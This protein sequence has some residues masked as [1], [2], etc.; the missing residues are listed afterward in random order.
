[1]TFYLGAFFTLHRVTRCSPL[2]VSRFWSASWPGE[3]PCAQF[4]L[5]SHG[6]FQDD[7]RCLIGSLVAL[8]V[9]L[10]RN[11][12]HCVS[13]ISLIAGRYVVFIVVLGGIMK[14]NVKWCYYYIFLFCFLISMFIAML[15]H[16]LITHEGNFSVP[17]RYQH[18]FEIG[19]QSVLCYLVVML[20]GK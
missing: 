8:A 10:H 3:T 15:G 6:I 11:A 2:L 20:L 4:G 12:P 16:I 14:Q 18:I 13:L 9:K 1:M 5:L 17:T 19:P 7:F